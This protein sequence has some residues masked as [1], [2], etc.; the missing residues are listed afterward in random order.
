VVWDSHP[1]ALGATPIQVFV[2]GIPQLPGFIK[3]KKPDNYQQTPR[4]PNFDKEAD[5][6]LKHEGLPPLQP[7]TKTR[8]TVVFAGVKSVYRPDGYKIQPEYTAQNDAELGV[9]VVQNGSITCL[10]GRETECLTDSLLVDSDVTLMNLEG[11]SVSP[12]LVSFG[13][14]LGLEEIQSESSTTDGFVPESLLKPIPE[15]LGGDFLL[16]HAEDGLQFGTRSA[17]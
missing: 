10:G 5:E 1:L 9:V 3:T 13:S 12:G 6:A 4:V 8:G 2:D 11:G 17:L 7:V 14:P 15:I 16:L